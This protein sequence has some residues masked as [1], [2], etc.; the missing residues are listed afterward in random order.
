MAF[1]IILFF[2]LVALAQSYPYS[3]GWQSQPSGWEQ[4]QP[5][6]GWEKPS[7]GWAQKEEPANYEFQYHVDDHHTK[8]IKAHHEQAS[9]GKVHGQ[10]WLIDSDGHKRIV[11]YTADD[12]NGFQATVRR[13]PTDIVVP[14]P[15]KSHGWENPASHGWEQK[16]LITAWEQ[17]KI[18]QGWAQ[19]P[20]S[21]GWEKKMNHGWEVQ[22]KIPSGWSQPQY[23]KW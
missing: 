22:S 23:K 9:N 12:H 2:A 20:I 4:Q 3:Q 6:N 13:E 17:P 16:P 5:S 7:H 21:S 14:I 11:D 10:Y 8:D 18:S 1:K 19:K 15:V